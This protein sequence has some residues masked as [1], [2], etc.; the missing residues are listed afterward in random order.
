[1]A[2]Q[3]QKHVTVNETFRR[4]DALVQLS[5]LSRATAAQ[6]ATPSEG[7]AYIVPA[8]ATGALWSTYPQGSIAVFQ[9]SAWVQISPVTGM[10]A[11]ITDEAALCVYNAGG[12]SVVSGGGG[13]SEAAPRFGINSLADNTNRLSVKSDAVLFS[14][15][16]VTPGNGD[17]QFKINKA[18][19]TQTASYLFQSGF[20][21]RAE[22]GLIGNNNFTIKVSPDNFA[23]SIEAL[24]INRANGFI[25]AG[26]NDPVHNFEVV[27]GPIG[28]KHSA[29]GFFL[30]ET[31]ASHDAFFVLDV[32]RLTVQ[33][34]ASNYGA[35]EG[36]V[37]QYSLT[38]GV[39]IGGPTGG[40]KGHGTLNAEAVYDDNALLSCYVFDQALD[41]SVD[42]EKWDRRVP[43]R[44]IEDEKGSETGRELRTHAPMRKFASRANTDFD[45][46][47][48]DG[49]ARHWKEKRH[50]TS[51]PNE[52]RFDPEVGLSTGDWIQRLIETAEIQAVLIEELNQRVKAL[53]PR[54]PVR[55]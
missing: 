36:N 21:G 42:V 45:P 27:G 28:I 17:I 48:L 20:S 2:S 22:F 1:M 37:V 44:I 49:Y 4:L 41:G 8:G 51:M 46:L 50:L 12:W 24:T 29:P 25:G 26:T 31:G 38:E 43:D 14:H 40:F 5:V 35:Y 3:A 9:D 18:S 55:K 32:G 54:Q 30:S 11:W 10:R 16:D 13:S 52:E 34:R 19:E 53:M 47:T 7:D 15:D 6:P 39:R 33:R 23:T